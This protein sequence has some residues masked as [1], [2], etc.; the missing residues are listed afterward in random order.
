M[1]SLAQ[2]SVPAIPCFQNFSRILAGLC[3]AIVGVMASSPCAVLGG[4]LDWNSSAGHRWA[5]LSVAPGQKAGFTILE[6]AQTGITFT[7][8]LDEW[9]SAANRVLL[10]G[11]GL[12]VGDYDGDGLPDIYFCSLVG[13]NALYRNLGNWRFE[14]VT[15]GAGVA[16]AGQVSRGAVF[17][18]VNGDGHLDLLVSTLAT[19]V[20]CFLN[21]GKGGF[22]DATL[23]ANT[24]S[25]FG[26]TTMTLADVDGN[27]TLDLYVANYR[28][29]DIRDRGQVDLQM[30]KGQ[31]TVPPKLRHRLLVVGGRVLE[32]GEPDV[33]LLNDGRG[34]FT[35][36]SWT[37]GAFLDEDG[38]KLTELLLDWGL[39]ASFRDITGN[40][41]PDLYVCNDYWTP[42]RIWIN[43]GKGRFRAI[44]RLAIRHTSSSS[45]GVDFADIDRD[46]HVDFIVTDMLSRDPRMRK[47]QMPAMWPVPNPVSSIEF[48][49]RIIQNTLMRSRGDGTFEEIANFSGV[50]ASD[51]TWQPLFIDVD[52][53]GYP[54]LLVTAG[55]SRD[56]QDMDANRIIQGRQQSRRGLTNAIERQRV[57]TQELMVHMRLYPK[58]EMPIFAFRNNGQLRFEET[59]D[60][61]GT[62]QR[63]V[64]HCM[65]LGDFDND[66][67][68]DLIVNNLHDGPGIYRNDSSAARVAVRLKGLPPNTQGVGSK[69]TLLRG[70]V[71]SQTEEIT[72]GGKY[73][74]GSEALA[75]FAAGESLTKMALEVRWRS[76]RVSLVDGVAA[77][78][79]YEIE[80]PAAVE[81]GV[82]QGPEIKQQQLFEDASFLLGHQHQ[83]AEF[84]DFARQSLLPRRLSNLGP[85]VAWFDLDGDGW[86]DL[87]VGSGRGGQLSVF[88]SDQKGGFKA[89]NEPPFNSPVTRDQTAVLGMRRAGGEAFILAGSANYEDGLATGAAA[90]Q[91]GMS[92]K[93][94]EESLPGQASSTGAVALADI[95][96]DGEL[97]LFI[98]GRVV[99]GRYPEPASSM[100]LRWKG[101]H[102]EIDG[103]NTRKLRNIGMV[104]GAVWSDLD[105]DGFPELVLACEWGPIRVF[106]NKAGELRE[107]TD[108]LGFDKF[109]GWW[110][111]VTTGDLDGDGRPDIIAANWG[112]NSEYQPSAAAPVRIYYGELGGRPALDVI[113]AIFDPGL[114]DFVP[115]QRLD[116]LAPS[117]PFLLG[118]FQTAAA[119]SEASIPTVLGP[120]RTGVRFLEAN[121]LA[122]M[123]FLNRGGRFQP[124]ELPREAQFAPAFAVNVADFDGDGHDDLFLSQNFFG[125]E[126]ELGRQDAG[127][128]LLLLGRGTGEFRAMPGQQSGIEIYGEQRGSAVGDFNKDGRVDLVVSQ[129]AA[130]TRLFLNRNG[131]PGLRVRIEGGAGNPSGVGAAVRLLYGDKAGPVKE[132]RAGSGYWSQDSSTLVMSLIE[133]PSKIWVRWPGGKITVTPVPAGARLGSGI[134]LKVNQ[135]KLTN[136]PSEAAASLDLEPRSK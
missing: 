18:D 11:A 49:P 65:A 33:L 69:I 129:N 120:K 101:G 23:T 35:P 42:D 130:G 50:A 112:L 126:P 102:W 92:S 78:R 84:N 12:A 34:R 13:A 25:P 72:S 106:E 45:M 114:G 79:I 22:A 125:T 52:L 19:G 1:S 136:S 21:D 124:L 32:Y 105:G 15:E 30:V 46:G 115:R 123:V 44:N 82:P 71:P 134:K 87:I 90:R 39:T 14:D 86:D 116:I 88:L 4:E 91:F 131:K 104:S 99:P 109:T 53:D 110:S 133:E 6:P 43:D 75:V 38:Q 83:E 66:G 31:L 57:F 8:E 60:M 118:Q 2:H 122:S 56:V 7:N 108:E 93:R 121:T 119:F 98:A 70:A 68:L 36:V 111:G 28:G 74:S 94:V 3:C 16:M 63:G 107:S 54:D 58:L 20:V 135:L 17:A 62:S 5:E 10:N 61:W 51:W 9:S 96:G 41:F 47:R 117:L 89:L 132:I 85:G 103:E 113:E 100:L 127:R 26:S 76:G 37:D 29:E 73:M 48:R 81:P 80:E 97:E 64:H 40:G 59:T 24:R 95:N 77:N 67:D 128:G 27:G 55:H